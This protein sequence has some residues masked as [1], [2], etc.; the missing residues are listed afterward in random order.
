MLSLSLTRRV[1]SSVN[2]ARR[3][4]LPLTEQDGGDTGVL[5]YY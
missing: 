4:F 1:T 2:F 5:L 3:Y